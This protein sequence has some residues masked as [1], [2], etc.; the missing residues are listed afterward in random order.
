MA[1]V[2]L[3][4]DGNPIIPPES[5]PEPEPKPEPHKFGHFIIPEGV[6]IKGLDTIG[7]TRRP[8]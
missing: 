3:D 1:V 8:K 5:P 6:H 4:K 2:I 7:E